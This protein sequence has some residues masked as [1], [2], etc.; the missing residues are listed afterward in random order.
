LTNNGRYL[1]DVLLFNKPRVKLMGCSNHTEHNVE[2]VTSNTQDTTAFQSLF[3]FFHRN[4]S[5]TG[6]W[7]LSPPRNISK[8]TCK[9]HSQ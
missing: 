9:L 4:T 3:F 1:L 6:Q 2:Y 8:V 7:W 5:V